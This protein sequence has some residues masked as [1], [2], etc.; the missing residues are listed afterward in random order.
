MRTRFDRFNRGEQKVFGPFSPN[1]ADLNTRQ[2]FAQIT[3]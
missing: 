3:F 1:A 2:V